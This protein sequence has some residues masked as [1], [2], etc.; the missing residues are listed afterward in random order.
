[1]KKK[2]KSEV[3]KW[4]RNKG[5]AFER[6]VAAAFREVYGDQVRRG[7]QARQ[8]SDAPDVEGVPGYW[9]EAKAHRKVN[10]RAAWKQVVAAQIDAKRKGDGRATDNP[11][12]ICKDDGEEP[13][14]VLR[15]SDFVSLLGRVKQL[16]ARGAGRPAPEFEN[17]D[18]LDVSG[19]PV[20][21]DRLVLVQ[22]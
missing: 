7:W 1:M 12:I 18:K 8:G 16:E 20:A 17:G 15:F 4:S 19:P 5:K 2:S 22:P 14:A 6:T 21:S 3:G 10:I 9:I 13:L 11:V